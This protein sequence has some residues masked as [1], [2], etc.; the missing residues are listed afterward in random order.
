MKKI[1]KNKDLF[2]LMDKSQNIYEAYLQVY[3]EG[4]ASE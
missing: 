1:N 3:S 4:I 2:I